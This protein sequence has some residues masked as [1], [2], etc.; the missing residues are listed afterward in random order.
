MKKFLSALFALGA[1]AAVQTIKADGGG[2]GGGYQSGWSD[3]FEQVILLNAT[4]NVSTNA[5]GVACLRT[6]NDCWTNYDQVKTKVVGL[7]PADYLVTV[8]DITGT[9]SY[10]LGTLTVS[11]NLATCLDDADDYSWSVGTNTVTISTNVTTFGSASFTLPS[12]LDPT[13]VAY[14]FIFDTNGIVDFT[15]DFTS[16]TNI[17]AVYYEQN[18]AITPG[19][20]AQAVGSGKIVLSYKNGKSTSNFLLSANNL[21]A[22]QSLTLNANGTKATT[23]TTSANG[24]VTVKSLPHT[25]LADLQILEARDKKGNLVFSLKF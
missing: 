17:A 9:N 25:K 20:A 1:L 23:A 18:V 13:N 15:G 12:G 19:T 6:E 3:D 7:S 4:T 5:I 14:L 8:T 2:C 21:P 10:D 22:K 11:T 24:A 16:T